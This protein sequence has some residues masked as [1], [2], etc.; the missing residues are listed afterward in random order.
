MDNSTYSVWH[1]NGTDSVLSQWYRDQS[2]LSKED[3]QKMKADLEAK[4]NQGW[5]HQ[6]SVFLDNVWPNEE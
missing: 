1:R 3:A 5:Y 2:G 4:S 6:V